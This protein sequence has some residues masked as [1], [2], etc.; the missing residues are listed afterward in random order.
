[1]LTPACLFLTIA[2]VQYGYALQA[3]SIALQADAAVMLVD[4]GSLFGGFIVESMPSLAPRRDLWR[5]IVSGVSLALLLSFT[6][7]FTVEAADTV[8]RKQT[9]DEDVMYT[10]VLIFAS[11]G[12]LFDGISLVTFYFKSEKNESG[13]DGWNINVCAGLLH[14]GADTLRSTTTLVEG[15]VI[16][17]DGD[18]SI[19]SKDQDGI[20]AIVV[21][22]IIILSTLYSMRTWIREFN[23]VVVSPSDRYQLNKDPDLGL[24]MSPVV[25]TS[26]ETQNVMVVRVGTCV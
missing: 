11:V 16:M 18:G 2:I 10:I 20:A 1:M 22:S 7:F 24:S 14:V 4:A 21:C 15:I 6:I 26:T 9:G 8:A 3:S 25:V 23:K 17:N 19:S 12:L 5:I 13:G